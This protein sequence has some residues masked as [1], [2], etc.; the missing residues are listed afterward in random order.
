MDYRYTFYMQTV[1]RIIGYLIV[2]AILFFV[3]INHLFQ[4][5]TTMNWDG[6]TQT[7]ANYLCAGFLGVCTL[8]L[9]LLSRVALFSER[10]ALLS[11]Y[12]VFPIGFGI[13]LYGPL[14]NYHRGET[15][16]VEVKD[17]VLIKTIRAYQKAWA[18]QCFVQRYVVPVLLAAALFSLLWYSEEIVNAM[19]DAL[20]WV[21]G[22]VLSLAWGA[23]MWLI[24]GARNVMVTTD[25]YEPERRYGW[26]GVEEIHFRKSHSETNEKTE[27]SVVW[28]LIALP[29]SIFVL[30]L[31]I[32]LVIFY[33]IFQVIRMFIPIGGR[34]TIFLHKRNI[35]IGPAYIPAANTPFN[36]IFIIL[37]YVVGF[38]FQYNYVNQDFW[39][40]GIGGSYIRENLSDRNYDYL[41]K[42]LDKIERKHGYSANI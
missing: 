28:S 25:Y 29:L 23:V 20:M 38:I 4:F 5:D 41:E 9:F 13:F 19:G 12:L 2:L 35:R 22:I 8:F 16:K 32:V 39:T 1:K 14:V 21:V 7:N 42:L 6:L 34:R 3:G 17:E 31:A 33:I 40:E 18:R 27:I 26:F 15:P 36:F 10:G 11:M 24:G 37:N 30:A